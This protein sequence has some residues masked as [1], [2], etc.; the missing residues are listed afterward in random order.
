[1][2]AR[3]KKITDKMNSRAGRAALVNALVYLIL[4]TVS[5]E[6]VYP[7]LRMLSMTFMSRADII[8]PAVN[9]IPTELSL[10][11]LRVSFYVL[12]MPRSL[13]NSVWFSSL[14]AALQTIVSAL[15]GYAFARFEFKFKRFWFVMLIVTFI[16]PLPMLAIPR[17]MIFV[18]LREMTG[19]RFIGT[20]I[21]QILLTAFGQGVHSTILILIF[22]NFMQMI[23]RSLDE[24][25]EIDGAGALQVF[26]H[27]GV[28]ISV[29]TVLVV[30]LM[31][32]IW[33]WNETFMTTMFLRGGIELLPGNLGLF[34]KIFG[35]RSPAA[36]PSAAGSSQINEAFS[37]A[38]T[39]IS[40]L[41]LITLY[42]FVQ[43]SF[44]KGIESTG[45]TGE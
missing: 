35:T 8:D 12:N 39:L 15:T 28:R 2:A 9:W 29:S 21:P 33:N 11:N 20:P 18:T 22:Y 31:S 10:A 3:I 24:A 5:Y 6:F 34:D 1:M 41:P 4:A 14:L 19:L 43:K 38:A 25:A 17:S 26:Y 32:A 42:F 13:F 23:P 36:M 30:F 37:M 27:I 45:V 44:I 40:V 16:L 7:L